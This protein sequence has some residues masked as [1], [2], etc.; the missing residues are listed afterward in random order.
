MA[1]PRFL[2]GGFAFARLTGVM[3]VEAVQESLATVLP[4]TGWDLVSGAPGGTIHFRT[5]LFDNRAQINF[6]IERT[7]A[8]TLVFLAKDHNNVICSASA[9]SASNM[10]IDTAEP[11]T[12]LV[13]A[14]SMTHCIIFC[15]G[16]HRTSAIVAILD[17]EPHPSSVAPIPW[18]FT[19]WMNPAPLAGAYSWNHQIGAY[20]LCAYPIR[21]H[22]DFVTDQSSIAISGTIMANPMDV[23][24]ARDDLP[25][26]LVGRMPHVLIV[27]PGI[28]QDTIITTPFDNGGQTGKFIATVGDSYTRLAVRYQ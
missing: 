4:S 16:S 19:K 26:M 27:D 23:L 17:T 6:W 22:S 3:D 24:I 21:R 12:E 15:Y 28:A 10:E 5:Q 25:S 18:Y 14:A 8:S 11:G 2:S 7:S 9:P 13:I 1:I 20:G